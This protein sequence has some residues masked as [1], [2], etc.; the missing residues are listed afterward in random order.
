MQHYNAIVI[1]SGQTGFIGSH[2]VRAGEELLES[3][4]IF[5][6]TGARPAVPHRDGLGENPTA[7][8]ATF[9]EQTF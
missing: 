8:T 7:S 6:D 9:Y 2:Q 5:I 3:E 4:R 1:G